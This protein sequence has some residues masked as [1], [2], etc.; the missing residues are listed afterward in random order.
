MYIY[1]LLLIFSSILLSALL[2]IFYLIWLF[3]PYYRTPKCVY[4]WGGGGV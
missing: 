2:F 4:V 3:M 1:P